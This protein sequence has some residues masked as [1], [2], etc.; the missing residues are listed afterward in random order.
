MAKKFRKTITLP[1]GGRKDIYANSE[2]ELEEK[3][4]NA[5]MQMRAGI[6]LS[7][8]PQFGEFAKLWYET[9]KKPKIKAATQEYYKNVLNNHILPFIGNIPIR[10]ITPM[11]I[12]ALMNNMKELSKELNRKTLQTLRAI[13]DSAVDN[14]LILKSPVPLT[15]K[16]GGQAA[17]KKESLSREQ[18]G[19]L[20][21]TLKG[22]GAYSFVLIALKTGMRRGEI[23][24]LKWDC[25][26]LQNGIIHVRRN[27]VFDSKTSSL[28]EYLKTDSSVRDLPITPVL[29]AELR[30]LK[31]ESNSLFVL[32]QKDGNQMTK[33]SFRA[34][35][36]NVNRRRTDPDKTPMYGVV[37]RCIDFEV[38]PHIL[39][40]TFLTRCFENG[41]DLK[42]VQYL[43]GHA[44]PEL[45]M[46]IYVH[47]QQEERKRATFTKVRAMDFA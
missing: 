22:S 15:L 45:T 12:A 3:V 27:L 14:N 10:N 35:W 16:A 43:A 4:L 47:Y 8:N 19:L 7:E 33:S 1:T 41:L 29:D 18:E 40:H 39:R 20:L 36:E 37:K 28:N 9:Y 44:T 30:R 17:Q 42:E 46:R 11:H 2:Q 23:C 26:D 34:M 38:T 6:N 31:S 32:H 25:V 5:K 21:E 13:F 24:G